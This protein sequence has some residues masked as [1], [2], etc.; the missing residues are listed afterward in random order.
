[1]GKA[2]WNSELGVF[3]ATFLNTMHPVLKSLLARALLFCALVSSL[4]LV[5]QPVWQKGPPPLAALSFG[6]GTFVAGSSDGTLLSSTDTLSWTPHSFTNL[7]VGGITFGKNLF[8]AA[9]SAGQILTS[10]NGNDWTPRLSGTSSNLAAI[11]FGNNQFIAVGKGGELI[12][13]TDGINWTKPSVLLFFPFDF[14][15]VTYAKGLFVAGGTQGVIYTSPDGLDWTY[16]GTGVSNIIMGLASD[17]NQFVA[18]LDSSASPQNILTSPNG[19]DWLLR[20]SGIQEGMYG[21]AA[22]SSTF[23]IVGYGGKLATSSDGI[24]WIVRSSDTTQL[25]RGVSYLN[26]GL[27]AFGDNGTITVSGSGINWSQT[28][29]S[30]ADSFNQVIY[31]SGKFVTVGQAALSGAPA[32]VQTS[33]DG[34]LWRQWNSAINGPLK[35][36][37]FGAGKFVAVGAGIFASD[38]ARTWTAAT[39]PAIADWT[40]V[41]YGNGLFVAVGNGSDF[42][43]GV[44]LTSPDGI[45]W[46]HRD[47]DSFSQFQGL[48]FGN[49]KFILLGSGFIATSSDGIN[50]TER[51]SDNQYVFNNGA[52][53]NGHFVVLGENFFTTH[54]GVVVTS[55]DGIKWTEG[56]ADTYD[57]LSDVTF[58]DNLFYLVGAYS[59]TFKSSVFTTPDG[60]TLTPLTVPTG[61]G[62]LTSVAIGPD[63]IVAVGQYGLILTSD[64]SGTPK[65]S[66]FSA[67]TF[68]SQTPYQSGRLWNFY[69]T[70]A[71]D[72]PGLFIRV[73]ATT[74]PVIESSWA[75]LPGG[76][77]MTRNGAAW[78]L[79]TRDV[80]AG[81]IYFRAIAAAPGYTDKIS[82]VQ[83]PVEI[84][85]GIAPIS[86]FKYFTTS[87]ARSNNTWQFT[88]RETSLFSDQRL[89]VQTTTTPTDE[90]SWTDLPGGGAMGH[91]DSS[92]SFSTSQVPTG[93]RYFRVIASATGFADRISTI[94]GP[95]D[96]VDPLQKVADPVSGTKQINVSTLPSVTQPVEVDV[97]A[98]GNSVITLLMDPDLTTQKIQAA[99]KMAGDA[100]S[101]VKLIVEKGKS[102]ITPELIV[103]VNSSV[104]L[105]GTLDGNIN[106]IGKELKT[107]LQKDPALAGEV[108]SALMAHGDLQLAI[109]LSQGNLHLSDLLALASDGQGV[110]GAEELPPLPPGF[111]PQASQAIS[112]EPLSRILA[113]A[114]ATDLTGEMTVTGDYSQSL[115]S[116]LAI[117]IGET[118]AVA[119][120]SLEY[121][122]LVVG[123]T[124]RLSGVIGF[125]FVN[126]RTGTN[127]Q[128][129]FQPPVGSVFDVVIASNI[130][131]TN[132]IVR[133]PVWADGRHFQW[134]VVNLNDGN[135]AVRLTTVDVAPSI[136]IETGATPQI[137]FPKNYAGYSLQQS[138]SLTT[139][140]WTTMAT[141]TNRVNI[142]LTASTRFFRLI[143]P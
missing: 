7:S 44:V 120:G 74:T 103:A 106:L 36:V 50:W 66:A 9:G 21:I 68:S 133:G 95:I 108:A 45:T 87:P 142:D 90:A 121:D 70:N 23:V 35:S 29:G 96:I 65:L 115:D 17:G 2:L 59:G 28:V 141:G 73:Q 101:L 41:A 93:H 112:R 33:V 140:T 61:A 14:R 26:G 10:P 22:S 134:R 88:A 118:N 62:P 25:L 76:G 78:T 37:A 94:L 69:G 11:T 83:G 125:G 47:F 40:K 111:P 100:G 97:N 72:A 110:L 136:A 113:A 31:A 132:L 138:D 19:V 56:P 128:D 131:T 48:F 58:A 13:S 80:P 52:F 122:R 12:R 60:T 135:Q 86:D 89:R 85:V 32:A 5:A 92:Y 46:T 34:L 91:L 24:T 75:D 16:Q 42:P 107:V 129:S 54:R 43:E 67:F 117:L 102:L 27:F 116:G 104:E 30:G 39:T 84:G 18:V 8:V 15:S 4:N 64:F 81:T 6:N 137:V 119:G 98:L 139:G 109:N 53:G 99:L 71:S 114:V 124:A 130:I 49:G 143:K 105:K 123:G 57:S 38:D 51:F 79:S 77:F 126:L 1:L 55:D 63:R 20:N 127:D 82:D 3:C